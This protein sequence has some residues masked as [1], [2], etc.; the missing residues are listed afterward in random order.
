MKTVTYILAAIGLMFLGALLNEA[1]DKPN[2]GL[3]PAE[4][5]VAQPPMAAVAITPDDLRVRTLET[6]VPSRP[7]HDDGAVY[8]PVASYAVSH[9]SNDFFG[10]PRVFV[11]IF[12]A[13]FVLM[14]L[15]GG[16]FILLRLTRSRRETDPEESRVMQDLHRL[17]CSLESRLNA[18]ET[19]LLDRGR[20]GH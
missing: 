7:A 2:Q 11:A 5:V 6:P 9:L 16:F 10:V 12:F 1:L 4:E 20:P 3:V 17:G 18:L 8:Y 19:I 15:A 13:A 14:L